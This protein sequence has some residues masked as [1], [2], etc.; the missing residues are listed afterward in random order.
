M[1]LVKILAVLVVAGLAN[2]AYWAL[3][4]QPVPLEAPPGGKLKSVSFAPFRDGQSPLTYDIPTPQQVE[5]DIVAIAPQVAGIRTYSSVDGLDVAPELARKHGMQVTMG[6]WLSPTP[7]QNER[8]IA[9]LIDLANRYPDVITRV[10]VGNEVLLRRD[11]NVDQLIGYIDRVK[12]AVKQPVSYADVWE[13]WIK[14]PQVADHVDLLTIH[15]L[16]YWEDVPASVE[17]STER[18][19]KS[20]RIIA[21]RF[22]GKPILV[23][24]TGWPTAGRS[25]GAAETGLV[26]KARF[27]NSFIRL[28]EQEGFDYNIIEA[29]DQGWKAKLEGTVGG[30]WGLYDSDRNAKF[31]LAGPVVENQRWMTY[32]IASSALALALWVWVM[33]QGG[34]LT[35]GGAGALALLATAQSSLFAQAVHGVIH[36]KHYWDDM[37]LAAVM[38]ALIAVLS[39][40]TLLAARRA[41]ATGALPLEPLAGLRGHPAL[42]RTET[43]GRLAAVALGAMALVWGL[44]IVWDGRY[45]DFPNAYMLAGAAGLVGLGALRA[46]RR[47]EG[48][49]RLGAFAVGS[50]F[51]Q[52]VAVPNGPG[53][54][55]RT[56][57]A[58]MPVEGALAI[59]LLLSAL[60]T[61][62]AEGFVPMESILYGQLP[63]MESL[64][65]VDWTQPN[66]EAL[67]WALLQLLLAVPFAAALLAARRD[68]RER[69]GEW[70]RRAA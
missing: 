40:T 31:S 19:R 33:T 34:R 66:W 29:F 17:D 64:H 69:T 16:P 18:I 47:P 57:V 62:L 10:I 6:A 43:V 4:N 1:R 15:L 59:G 11:L 49:G 70:F 51:R 37:L 5:E 3:P 46:L 24:E 14:Y 30:H 35:A 22:P 55:L 41:L 61:V 56:A 13:W 26:E 53:V 42:S 65:E 7:A 63:I 28:A 39:V 12:A 9:A 36:G 25:R 67:G 68:N 23:G 60:L 52:A 20:Y 50:L 58:A 2:F 38:L 54:S 48:T 21:E 27:V 44:L 32:F 45:R 8:E